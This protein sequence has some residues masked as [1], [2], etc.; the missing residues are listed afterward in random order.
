MYTAALL[1]GERCFAT[2]GAAID[3]AELLRASEAFACSFDLFLTLDSPEEEELFA[4]M[5]SSLMSTQSSY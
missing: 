5:L 2:R 1:L 4:E 3:S